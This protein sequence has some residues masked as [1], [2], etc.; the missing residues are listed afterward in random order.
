M[1]FVGVILKEK[2][3]STA[4]R[5][6]TDPPIGASAP[7]GHRYPWTTILIL[8]VIAACAIGASFYVVAPVVDASMVGP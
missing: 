8:G 4:V 6:P 2:H 1:S 5:A 3:M 7:R